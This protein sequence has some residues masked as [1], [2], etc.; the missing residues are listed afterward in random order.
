MPDF[1]ETEYVQNPRPNVLIT[2]FLFVLAALL[3]TIN[4][5]EAAK[6]NVVIIF[7]DDQG[8]GDLRSGCAE[9]Q[10]AYC[11]A[12][13]CRVRSGVPAT[14]D[15]NEH[16]ECQRDKAHATAVTRERDLLMR[17][18]CSLAIFFSHKLAAGCR[19][20]AAQRISYCRFLARSFQNVG[21]C[22]DVVSSR[23]AEMW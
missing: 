4:C 20:V 23:S 16:W 10:S 15:V 1:T 17:I 19:D 3:P 11:T 9:S 6:P 8:Y 22:G 5:V 7:I 13:R 18:D 2:R 12:A 21:E 14:D